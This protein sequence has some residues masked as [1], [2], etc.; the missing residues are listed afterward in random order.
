MKSRWT[1]FGFLVSCGLFTI[2]WAS[3]A[4][5]HDEVRYGRYVR[6]FLDFVDAYPIGGTFR[7]YE[8]L[9]TPAA[10]LGIFHVLNPPLWITT[11]GA[12]RFHVSETTI[13]RSDWR[14]T[15]QALSLSFWWWWLLDRLARSVRRPRVTLTHLAVVIPALCLAV[16]VGVYQSLSG[17]LRFRASPLLLCTVSLV[18]VSL[19]FIWARRRLTPVVRPFLVLA[20]GLVCLALCLW[21]PFVLD[22]VYSS[23]HHWFSFGGYGWI[24]KAQSLSWLTETDLIYPPPAVDLRLHVAFPLLAIELLLVGG[25]VIASTNWKPRVRMGYEQQAA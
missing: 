23:G 18:T 15:A 7:Q 12:D 16:T 9:G 13:W 11:L 14:F 22:S 1:A 4:P 8:N 3:S 2:Y 19:A 21:P 5:G 17:P 20:G 24:M 10:A 6:R 25:L